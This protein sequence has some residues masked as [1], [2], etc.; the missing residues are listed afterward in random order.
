MLEMQ[1]AAYKDATVLLLTD[2]KSRMR[3]IEV[4]HTE[5]IHSLEFT[6]K[7]MDSLKGENKLLREEI[8]ALTMEIS[9]KTEVEEK[10][11]KLN[12]RMDYQEDYSRRNNLRFD[13]MD[14]SPYETWEQTQ[15][16]VQRLLRDKL[17]LGTVQLERAHRVGSRFDQGAT[18]PRTVVARFYKFEDRQMALKNSSKLK[19]TNIFINEDLCGSSVQV[20]KNLLPELRK[21]RNEGKIAYFSHTKLVVKEKRERAGQSQGS[22]TQPS[23]G[24][25]E[26]T[27]TSSAAGDGTGAAVGAGPGDAIGAG[28][29]TASGA[30]HSTASGT[31]HG[32]ASG[33]G[34]GT[35]SGAGHGTASGTG[36]DT[37]SDAENG[38]G[39]SL[40]DTPTDAS[41]TSEGGNGTSKSLSTPGREKQQRGVVLRSTKPK[42]FD[43]HSRK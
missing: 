2:V 13:G 39:V 21:A 16:K 18:R 8:L 25:P 5:L 20:R 28:H 35:A 19:N 6:Q 24:R 32:T 41:L 1:Q 26:A 11:N 42:R 7:E 12:E 31:G 14:E 4:N 9:K 17:E 10:L 38:A 33:A 40:A 23:M 29:G 22:T 3:Q 27:S 30:G 34:H 15:N 37:A 43:K 36:H